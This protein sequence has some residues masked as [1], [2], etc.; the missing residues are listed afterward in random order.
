MQ[1]NSAKAKLLLGI[2]LLTAFLMPVRVAFMKSFAIDE[3]LYSH[4]GWLVS[5]GQRIGVDFFVTHFPL[6]ACLTSLPFRI[7]GSDPTA[8]FYD[9]LLMLPLFGLTCVASYTINSRISPTVGILTPILLCLN[10][11]LVD[12]IIEI[13]P[14]SLAIALFM[15]ASAILLGMEKIWYPLSFCGGVLFVLAVLSSEK[16]AIYSPALLLAIWVQ[17][18]RASEEEKGRV[19][20]HVCFAAGGATAAMLVVL[21]YLFHGHMLEFWIKEWWPYERLHESSYPSSRWTGLRLMAT[22]CVQEPI[23]TMLAAWAVIGMVGISIESHL[24]SWYLNP[25]QTFIVSFLATGSISLLIQKAPFRYSEIPI[26][27]AITM[28]AAV[29]LTDFYENAKA[30]WQ[31]QVPTISIVG[32]ASVLVLFLVTNIWGEFKISL[33]GNSAQL[34]TLHFLAKISSPLEC[35]YDNSG[36]AVARPHADDRFYQTDQVTRIAQAELLQHEIPSAIHSRGCA[37]MLE[38]VRNVSLPKSLQQFL[39]ENYYPYAYDISVW[40]RR[41]TS[42]DDLSHVEVFSAV[43]TGLY[44]LWPSEASIQ[45][46]IVI[47]G[48]EPKSQS[49]ILAKGDHAVQF[50]GG[51]RFYILWLPKNTQPFEPES[52]SALFTP[53]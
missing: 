42:Y 43:A 17:F 49:F 13:R 5:Q 35:V 15:A 48:V 16:V 36:G 7:V 30:R 3:F 21:L 34:R 29:G 14:D 2:I 6:I 45:K 47:D 12:S 4:W 44:F 20:R 39:A 38:D 52:K 50:R 37:L 31:G 10:A 32:T 23:L 41:F 40:G 25:V 1:L 8:I 28:L 33:N 26:A 51:G 46:G 18:H 11:V 53:K 22:F 9:R 24:Q 27:V 19:A